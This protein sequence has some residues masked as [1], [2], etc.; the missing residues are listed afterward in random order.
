MAETS[1][2]TA[3]DP[4]EG[5]ATDVSL[6][7]LVWDAALQ[8]AEERSFGFKIFRVRM[9]LGIEH[10]NKYDRT[11]QRTLSSME[12]LGWL[13]RDKQQAHWWRPG[14]KIQEAES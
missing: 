7:D 8:L 1:T 5:Y 12:E 3:P 10:W 11:I 13:R 14:P 6:R 4:R 9:K 2:G